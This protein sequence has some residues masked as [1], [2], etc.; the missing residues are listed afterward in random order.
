MYMI[1]GPLY[2]NVGMVYRCMH[3]INSMPPHGN[4]ICLGANGSLIDC[5]N[6]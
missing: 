1:K 2:N 5:H 6:L 3:G 4:I